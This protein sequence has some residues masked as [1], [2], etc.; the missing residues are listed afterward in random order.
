MKQIIKLALLCTVAILSLHAKKDKDAV[1][2]SINQKVGR[3]R[4]IVTAINDK[5]KCTYEIHASDIGTTG[6]TITKPGTYCLVDD[7]VFNP[8][9]PAAGTVIAAITIASSN[10]NLILGDHYLG[11]AGAGTSSQSPFV[12]GILVPDVI[13]ASTDVNAIGLQSVYINGDQA[14]IDG[15]S[16]Y[17]VRIFG[18]TYDIRLSNMTIKNCGLLASKALRPNSN[19]LPHSVSSVATCQGKPTP[20]FPQF[21]VP[22]GVAGLCIGE[23]DSFGQG[24]TFFTQ[25]SCQV[26]NRVTQVIIDNVSCLNNFFNGIC[27]SN[28]SEI[29]INNCHFDGTFSDDPGT[30]S[31]AAIAVF[32]A[33]FG[34]ANSDFEDPNI[35]N[36]AVNN[37]TFNSTAMRGDFT[38]SLQLT[39]NNFPCAGLRMAR[40]RNTEFNNCSFDNT[41]N[42]FVGPLI[43]TCGGQCAGIEDATWINCSFDGTRSLGIAQ[44]FHVSGFDFSGVVAKSS[45]NLLFLDCTANNIQQIGD[46]RLPAPVVPVGLPLPQVYGFFA[47]WVKGLYMQNCTANDIICNGPMNTYAIG[48]NLDVLPTATAAN[49]TLTGCVTSRVYALNGGKAVGFAINGPILVPPRD[50]TVSFINCIAEDC[51]T[52]VPT[53]TGL[54]LTQ[55]VACGFYYIPEVPGE[56]FPVTYTGCQALHNKGLATVLTTTSPLDARYSAGFYV[57]GGELHSFYDC[58]AL[59]N[60]Y[61]FLLQNSDACTLRNC[62][63]DNNGF[64]A[65][66]TPGS[67]GEGFTDLE[68]A[69]STSLFEFNHA[70][71]NGTGT[72]HTGANG[73]YNVTYPFGVVP[74]LNGSLT[75]GYPSSVT[76]RPVDNISIIK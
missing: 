45:R 66:G 22:F 6:Y 41:T 72:I 27:M 56:N 55:D 29:T 30:T 33:S 9:T 67:V 47:T 69:F 76:F 24:P 74:T 15:F 36:M 63:S 2:D 1:L 46:Q 26:Q 70:F 42:T 62:R 13:P 75:T 68:A 16:M 60:V 35:L 54:G 71:E 52:F 65:S 73:N 43:N 14:I 10:V 20:S 23:S 17:G 44:G 25:K 37:T 8:P 39:A 28:T 12:V 19:Y 59:D 21:G 61:G 48:F 34:G 7:V 50:A 57:S 38:T 51:Q 40:S 4:Q 5:E 11:Q 49:N 64:P 3:I 31:Q 53:L 58:L 18:H 32:G